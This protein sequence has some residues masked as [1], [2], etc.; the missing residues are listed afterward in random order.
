[1]NPIK[2]NCIEKAKLIN[3]TSVVYPGGGVP[4][5]YINTEYIPRITDMIP[6]IIPAPIPKIKGIL[7]NEAT[8]LKEREINLK[9][10]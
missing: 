5:I 7:E 9:N 4:I 2:K 3:T 10:E 8:A 6:K 1:M